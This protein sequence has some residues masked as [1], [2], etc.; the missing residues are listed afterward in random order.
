MSPLQKAKLLRLRGCITGPLFLQ[1]IWFQDGKLS[2]S[3]GMFNA[4]IALTANQVRAYL[5]AK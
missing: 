4:S 2:E 1:W 5:K 3:E